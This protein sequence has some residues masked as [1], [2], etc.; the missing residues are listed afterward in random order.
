M[1]DNRFEQLRY[2]DKFSLDP[3]ISMNQ[4]AK[5]MDTTAAT[6]SKLEHDDDYDARISIIKKYK[7]VFPDV[8]YDYLLGATY[9][10]HKQYN[11]IEEKL[12]FGNEF[13]D[14]LEELFKKQQEELSFGM[15]PKDRMSM[16]NLGAFME[17]F[18]LDPERLLNTFEIL[19]D[20]FIILRRAE[21]ND[22]PYTDISDYYVMNAK[23]TILASMTTLLFDTVYPSLY[24]LLDKIIDV[25][26][27]KIEQMVE[28][29]GGP[30]GLE[31]SINK[32][33]PFP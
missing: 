21:R 23:S 12:P 10:K 2:K 13:Y 31:E 6:I 20:Q 9:T 18:L 33:I 7:E 16:E 29:N 14:H 27:R 1:A 4:L 17:A 32:E 19:M 5:K 30:F 25:S 22:L 15:L 8:S 3:E 28:D 24:K 26:N 11:R